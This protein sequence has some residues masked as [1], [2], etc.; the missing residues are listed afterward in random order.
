MEPGDIDGKA[1][2]PSERERVS[3]TPYKIMTR[4]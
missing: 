3:Q 1:E 2:R 4:L